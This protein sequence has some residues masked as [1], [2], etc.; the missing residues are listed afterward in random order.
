MISNI[1]LFIIEIFNLGMGQ[2]HIVKKAM[3]DA[4]NQSGVGAGG[5]RNI[6]GSSAYHV[7]LEKEIADLHQKD[8]A[9]VFSSGFV[10]NQGALVAL[11]KVFPDIIYLSDA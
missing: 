5:T 6:G 10:A 3:I 9:L 11:A 2:N 7:Q 8:S 4:I 1:F